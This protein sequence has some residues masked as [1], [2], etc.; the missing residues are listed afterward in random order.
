MLH[1][2]LIIQQAIRFGQGPRE[3][4]S[5]GTVIKEEYRIPADVLILWAVEWNT[6]LNSR[7]NDIVTQSNI[8]SEVIFS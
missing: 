2:N 6:L 8:L 4:T 1:S 3:N 5:C 7:C